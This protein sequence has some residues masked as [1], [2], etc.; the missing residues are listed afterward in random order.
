MQDYHVIIK[1]PID[2]GVIRRRLQLGAYT[3]P[4]QYVEDV[5]LMFANAYRY[6]R[7]EHQ[8]YKDCRKVSTVLLLL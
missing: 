1:Q 5:N 2:L 8:P 3:D 7:P 4:W 6:N